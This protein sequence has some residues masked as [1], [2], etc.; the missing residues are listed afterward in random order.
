MNTIRTE[1]A[2]PGD[3]RYPHVERAV[4]ERLPRLRAILP[5]MAAEAAIAR[6][7]A[8]RLRIENR[9]LTQCVAEL[10]R[11]LRADGVRCPEPADA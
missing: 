7:E 3:R 5:A 9:H 6:R 11:R 2:G 10:E 8:A 1:S 4:I